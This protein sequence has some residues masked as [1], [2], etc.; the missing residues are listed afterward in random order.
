MSK[1]VTV[2]GTVSEYDF[3]NPHGEILIEVKKDD[4]SV[5]T[6]RKSCVPTATHDVSRF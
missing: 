2:K 1:L 6:W 5:E 4:H 3:R